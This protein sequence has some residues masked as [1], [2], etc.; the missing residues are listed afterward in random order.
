MTQGTQKNIK[1]NLNKGEL[2]AKKWNQKKRKEKNRDHKP[3]LVI[4]P[5]YMEMSLGATCRVIPN[6]KNYI[7]QKTEN[8]KVKMVLS[9]EGWNQWEGENI[10][11]G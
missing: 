7:F 11:K 4:I 3:I 6:N 1:R 9:G 5:I 2:S 8:R 10:R